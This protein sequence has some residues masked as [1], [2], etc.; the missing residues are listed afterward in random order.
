MTAP[1]R[2]TIAAPLPCGCIIRKA[3]T[4]DEPAPEPMGRKVAYMAGVL[5][6]WLHDRIPRHRCDLVNEQNPNGLERRVVDKQPRLVHESPKSR[7]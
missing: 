2:L 5:A 6:S 7:G 3:I 1:T 4:I